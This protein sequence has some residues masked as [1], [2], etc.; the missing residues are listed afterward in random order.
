MP[1]LYLVITFQKTI[2]T[3]CS[4]F[5]LN[6]PEDN[7]YNL[8]WSSVAIQSRFPSTFAAYLYKLLEL[9]LP[10]QLLHNY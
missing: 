8:L 3:I 2:Y 10:I 1:S 7:L 5:S 4:L 6:I 9:V